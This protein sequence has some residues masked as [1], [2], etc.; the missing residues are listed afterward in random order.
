MR[1]TRHPMSSD[2]PGASSSDARAARARR[3]GLPRLIRVL[4]PPPCPGRMREAGE[5]R[6][7]AQLSEL[8]KKGFSFME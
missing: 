2:A 3:S 5:A 6:A 7:H 8:R 1:C 4:R